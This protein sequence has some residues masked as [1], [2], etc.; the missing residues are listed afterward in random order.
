MM[1]MVRVWV[2]LVR[3]CVRAACSAH[4]VQKPSAQ[5][6]VLLLTLL[7]PWP[8]LDMDVS[9]VRPCCNKGVRLPG[10]ECDGAC[11]CAWAS[12]GAHERGC[13]NA[14]AMFYL[15]RVTRLLG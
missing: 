14:C 1:E 7:L 9:K 6:T 15:I 3:G 12:M 8:Q 5:V 4:H 10:Y 13:V 2:R 11:E